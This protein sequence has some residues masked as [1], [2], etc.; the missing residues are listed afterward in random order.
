MVEFCFNGNI[1]DFNW[2]D[3]E[4]K[5]EMKKKHPILFEVV[6]LL[7]DPA[8]IV[9]GV[10]LALMAGGVT[11]I[12]LLAAGKI[13][14]DFAGLL[15]IGGGFASFALGGSVLYGATQI[16][17]DTQSNARVVEGKNKA[18]SR[19]KEKENDMSHTL[20][21][22]A[23]KSENKEGLLTR[24]FAKGATKGK[25][26]EERAARQTKAEELLKTLQE[27]D[28]ND[29]TVSIKNYNQQRQGR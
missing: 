21:K 24:A 6:D 12:G 23:V 5:E 1:I 25:T 17:G 10:G 15:A 13:A 3:N 22:M 16:S 9:G 26:P 2:K 4:M 29:K 27:R 8:V 28:K 18:Q 11:S 7:T 19:T 20:S 14:G